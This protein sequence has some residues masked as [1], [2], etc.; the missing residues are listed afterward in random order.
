MKKFIYCLLAVLLLASISV[1]A[2][3]EASPSQ[4]TV[5]YGTDNGGKEVVLKLTPWDNRE[6]LTKEQQ[7]AFEAAAEKIEAIEDLKAES[8]EVAKAAGENE[9]SLS[10]MFFVTADSFPAIFTVDKAELATLIGAWFYPAD[11]GEPIF[12]PVVDGKITFPG[13]GTVVFVYVVVGAPG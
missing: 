5:Y 10:G 1:L 9:I 4:P 13:E 11:G 12:I 2:F 7:E 6:T 8:E 3:A